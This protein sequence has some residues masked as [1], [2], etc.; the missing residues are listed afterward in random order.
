MFYKYNIHL[1]ETI[2]LCIYTLKYSSCGPKT[3]I[4]VNTGARNIQ[5]RKNL[6]YRKLKFISKS[7]VLH[8]FIKI[9]IIKIYNVN[10]QDISALLVK[11]VGL[12]K[13]V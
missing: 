5:S 6:R 2:K 3:P 11:E 4:L 9:H 7:S 13:I 1:Q 8:I 10:V 12:C